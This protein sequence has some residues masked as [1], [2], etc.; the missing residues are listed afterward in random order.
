[1]L[2]PSVNLSKISKYGFNK[3]VLSIGILV[4]IFLSVLITGYSHKLNVITVIT[5]IT[6]ITAFAQSK[7]KQELREEGQKDIIFDSAQAAPEKV[8]VGDNLTIK[9]QIQSV[10]PIE[11]VTADVAGID[12]IELKEQTDQNTQEQINQENNQTQTYQGI[13]KVHD[14]KNQKYTII[15][16]AIDSKGNSNQTQTYFYDPTYTCLGGGD[17]GGLDWDPATDCP[18]GVAGSH[19]NIGTLTVAT[20]ETATVQAYNGT[21]Y[22]SFQVSATNVDIEGTLTGV[23]LIIQN[24]LMGL[25]MMCVYTNVL[26]LLPKSNHCIA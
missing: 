11:K 7:P 20:G 17:H 9:T 21:S 2:K 13:W 24:I 5:E 3:L 14:T 1:M 15:I 8:K 6:P 10:N 26:Y 16:T 18:G 19:T 25:W 22:G 4:S 23:I 12:V